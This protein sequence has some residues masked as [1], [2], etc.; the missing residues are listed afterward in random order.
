M[1]ESLFQ[2]CPSYKNIYVVRTLRMKFWKKFLNKEVGGEGKEGGARLMGRTFGAKNKKRSA[3]RH[4]TQR[5]KWRGDFSKSWEKETKKGR[6]EKEMIPWQKN[7]V[8]PPPSEFLNNFTEGDFFL[9]DALRILFHGRGILMVPT[10]MMALPPPSKDLTLLSSF[11]FL[12][13]GERD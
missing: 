12:S 11:F 6:E 5:K 8:L 2:C 4:S 1:D 9:K 13:Q 10:H 7:G 3:V